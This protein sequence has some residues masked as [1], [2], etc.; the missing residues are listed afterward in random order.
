MQKTESFGAFGHELK[1]G[2]KRRG[3]KRRA[4]NLTASWSW[5]WASKTEETDAN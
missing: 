1:D 4:A 5:D 2:V 3:M